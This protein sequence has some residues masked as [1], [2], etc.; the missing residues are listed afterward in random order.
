M[1]SVITQVFK[2][3]LLLPSKFTFKF[4]LYKIKEPLYNS[5][6]QSEK[7]W[8]RFCEKKNL[9]SAKILIQIRTT[10]VPINKS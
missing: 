8:V 3:S 5:R 6:I 2:K 4:P 7:E 10:P 9:K 1:S